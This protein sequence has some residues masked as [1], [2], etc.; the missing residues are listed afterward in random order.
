MKNNYL[1]LFAFLI[2]SNISAQNIS[3][4]EPIIFGIHGG[5]NF[6]NPNANQS[7]GFGGLLGIYV[8]IKPINV[9]NVRF[10]AEL[11]YKTIKVVNAY[12][13]YDVKT[14]SIELPILVKMSPAISNLKQ[15]SIIVGI[16]P[17][18]PLR[19]KSDFSTITKFDPAINL[20]YFGGIGFQL[21]KP[22]DKFEID[23]RYC[24]YVKNNYAYGTFNGGGGSGVGSN[25]TATFD[26]GLLYNFGRK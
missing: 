10:Q 6:S 16:A 9:E 12:R 23:V 20:S 17:S 8:E 19:S 26:V 2:V 21:P 22:N 3:M 24:G 25:K 15:F 18:V 4:P 11:A 1:F 5:F 14:Q 7:S 13:V